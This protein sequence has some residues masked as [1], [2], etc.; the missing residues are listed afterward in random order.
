M[1][2]AIFQPTLQPV[3]ADHPL[4]P[5]M[6]NPNALAQTPATASASANDN[7]DEDDDDDDDDEDEYDDLI[8]ALAA[9]QTEEMNLLTDSK[10]DWSD[11]AETSVSRAVDTSASESSDSECPGSSESNTS[12]YSSI[13]FLTF[14]K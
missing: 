13:V 12:E 8:R 9:L 2:K 7:E 3:P 10:M 1:P 11:A 4:L 6:P 5:P 14:Y